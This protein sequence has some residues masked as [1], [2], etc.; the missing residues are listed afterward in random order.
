MRDSPSPI[1]SH[2]RATDLVNVCLTTPR[3]ADLVY[4]YL[5]ALRDVNLV[6]INLTAL[7]AADLFNVRLARISPGKKVL[8]R[9]S[10]ILPCHELLQLIALC[11]IRASHVQ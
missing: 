9:G 7:R 10:L 11:F 4:V 3:T 2:L 8:L 6:N 5:T 1:L